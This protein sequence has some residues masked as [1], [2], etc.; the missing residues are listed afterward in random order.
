MRKNLLTLLGIFTLLSCGREIIDDEYINLFNYKNDTPSNITIFSYQQGIKTRHDL[1]KDKIYSQKLD[2]N[3]G[4]TDK[5]IFYADSVKIVYDNSKF[6]VWKS[7][8]ESPRNIIKSFDNYTKLKEEPNY[9]EYSFV[10]ITSD[11]DQTA[12]CKGNCD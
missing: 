2:N 3:F 4:S 8:D 6:K 1:P 10:F 11:L 9:S 12:V 5:I 7:S